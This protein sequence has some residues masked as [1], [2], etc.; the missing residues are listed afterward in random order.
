MS[1]KSQV[2]WQL[3]GTLT[4]I[5]FVRYLKVKNKKLILTF[6]FFFFLSSSFFLYF[7]FLNSGTTGTASPTTG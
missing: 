4:T 1:K 3:T 5:Y 7:I 2:E 6:I